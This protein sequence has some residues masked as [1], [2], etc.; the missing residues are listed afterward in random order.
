MFNSAEKFPCTR[1]GACCA[2]IGQL[3]E[4]A[5]LYETDLGFNFPINED[6]SC[7]HKVSTTKDN[8]DSCTGCGIYET[9]PVICRIEFGVPDS[10]TTEEYFKLTA[11]ACNQL[12]EQ[13]GIDDSFR[14]TNL[15]KLNLNEPQ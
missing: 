10:M 9:R 2:N 6:G 5:K 1:C 14:I 3:V 4:T 11:E 7:G 15:K 8:G 13:Q 12:Q